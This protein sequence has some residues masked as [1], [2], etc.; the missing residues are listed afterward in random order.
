MTAN[1]ELEIKANQISHSFSSEVS[2]YPSANTQF[3]CALDFAL[4]PTSEI[5]IVGNSRSDDTKEMLCDIHTAFL[6]QKILLFL[7]KEKKSPRIFDLVS[8]IN[9]YKAIEGKATAYVCRQQTC[10]KPT[11]DRAEML[12]FLDIKKEFQ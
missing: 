7:P 5:V 4:G 9:N 11:T 2:S 1:P 8:F 12:S 6:P 10:K 3:L